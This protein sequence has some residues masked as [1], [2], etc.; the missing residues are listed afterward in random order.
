MLGL[1][2][3]LIGL[4]LTMFSTIPITKTLENSGT[5]Y[6][7]INPP[8]SPSYFIP[9]NSTLILITNTN[10][11]I[12]IT[13]EFIYNNQRNTTTL[14]LFNNTNPITIKGTPIISL[15]NNTQN[16]T[17]KYIISGY[18]KP[19]LL[20]SLPGSIILLAGIIILAKSYINIIIES[21]IEYNHKNN[22]TS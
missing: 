2:V 8:N 13:L 9:K 7:I 17:Y 20:L 16:I 1:I 6:T 3:A 11:P 15:I 19:W 4:I 21:S 5:T 22:N 18:Q 10:K 12:N 14:T